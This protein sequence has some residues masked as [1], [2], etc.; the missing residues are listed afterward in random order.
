MF[1]QAI[2][3]RKSH[4]CNY[5]LGIARPK[6]PISCVG[7]RFLYSQDRSTYFPATKQA[8]RS[9][10]YINL[11]KTYECRNWVTEHYNYNSVLEITVS[12]LGRHKWELD[13]YIGFSPALIYSAQEIILQFRK[14]LKC[15]NKDQNLLHN[16]L[17]LFLHTPL[18]QTSLFC[19]CR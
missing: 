6:S 16:S 9:W 7:E 15:I 11:S 19:R 1:P 3:L 12:F 13:I 8:D 10:K 18:C 14:I 5:F 2:T 4:L 17:D